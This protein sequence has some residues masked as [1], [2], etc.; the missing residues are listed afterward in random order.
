[1][2]TGSRPTETRPPGTSDR[3]WKL[4][5]RA[6]SKDD[7]RDLVEDEWQ[8]WIEVM[9]RRRGWTLQ[10]HVRRAQVK[11]AWIT[12]TSS[13][14]VPDLWLLR[15][16][17]APR[18]IVLECKSERGRTSDEQLAWIAGLQAAGIPA[19]IVKPSDAAEVLALLGET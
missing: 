6:R 17:P 10:F 9:A 3:T 4:Y 16:A 1:M 12:N 14:G 13:P 18:L 15:G 8:A 7:L 2:P 19:Y 11:G 5:R